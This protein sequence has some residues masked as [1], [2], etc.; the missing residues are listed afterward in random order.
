M[1]GVPIRVWIAIA[2]YSVLMTTLATPIYDPFETGDDDSW[3]VV[4]LVIGVHVGIGL[5]IARWWALLAPV[6]AMGIGFFLADEA[7][8]AVLLLMF[9]L[10]VLLVVT[11]AACFGGRKL[12]ASA[13]PVALGCFAVAALPAAAGAVEAIER[14]AAPHVPRQVQAE[15]PTGGSTC[16]ARRRIDALVGQLRRDP[17][18]LVTYTWTLAHGGEEKRDITVREV[19][20]EMLSSG[21]CDPETRRRLESA[22]GV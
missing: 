14:D 3:V 7:V 9:A 6:C 22:L 15:L 17:H 13:W 19:A 8:G 16:E 2:V 1:A 12:H 10:P 20:E 4:V 21:T 5:A 18:A 11:A